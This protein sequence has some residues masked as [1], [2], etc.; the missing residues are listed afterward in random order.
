LGGAVGAGLGA[1]GGG[2]AGAAVGAYQGATGAYGEA[3]KKAGGGIMGTIAGLG[4]G[5]MGGIGGLVSGGAAGAVGGAGYGVI[6]GGQFGS[7]NRKGAGNTFGNFVDGGLSA[8]G[9]IHEGGKNFSKGAGKVATGIGTIGGGIIGAGLGGVVGTFAGAG[10][11]ASSAY[12]NANKKAGGGILGGI[13]GAG[14][15]LLGGIAGAGA[16]AVGGAVL[17]AQEL[18]GAALNSDPSKPKEP[19]NGKMSAAEKYLHKNRISTASQVASVGINTAK[20]AEQG[21]KTSDFAREA[22]AAT[23]GTVTTA[24]KISG[25]GGAALGGITAVKG[26]IDWYRG[27]SKI[28]RNNE[29]LDGKERGKDLATMNERVKLRQKIEAGK[30]M[31]RGGKYGVAS[32]LLSTAAGVATATGIGAPIGLGLGLASMAVSGAGAIHGAAVQSGRDKEARRMRS[33]D[34]II[35]DKI[36]NNQAR[37]ERIGGSIF[38]PMNWKAKF[39]RSTGLGDTADKRMGTLSGRGKEEDAA[40]LKK[41]SKEKRKKYYEEGYNYKDFDGKETDDLDRK[42]TKTS[43]YS[44]FNPKSWGKNAPQGEKKSFDA[45]DIMFNKSMHSKEIDKRHEEEIKGRE[46]WWHWSSK[47]GEKKNEIEG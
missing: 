39:E 34:E 25:I 14:A 27:N 42:I 36:Q 44:K 26:G 41:Y 43:M 31:K 35:E 10:V 40:D 13:L 15:G 16:G 23:A 1:V 46:K 24:A 21:L 18:G 9:S 8:A 17:G 3:K 6:A 2:L 19:G 38:N 22:M 7:G 4:A 12:E 30:D 32:G 20:Y 29:K 5:L 33:K 45:E 28:K 37:E 11:G 47:K